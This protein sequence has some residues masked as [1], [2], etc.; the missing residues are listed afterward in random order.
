MMTKNSA[1][2]RVPN[3]IRMRIGPSLVIF[4]TMHLSLEFSLP[5]SD[6]HLKFTDPGKVF[7]G[8]C[9]SIDASPERDLA[10][11]ESWYYSL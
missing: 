6:C 11:S 1:I 8:I 7:Y 9:F 4:V 5:Q 10:T 2:P 3:G